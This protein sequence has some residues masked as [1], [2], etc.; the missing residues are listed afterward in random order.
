MNQEEVK[1]DPPPKRKSD[2]TSLVQAELNNRILDLLE[3]T[4]KS[5]YALSEKIESL[6]DIYAESTKST[7]EDLRTMTASLTNLGIEIRVSGDALERL[8]KLQ[9]EIEKKRAEETEKKHKL[10]ANVTTGFWQL[11]NKPINIILVAAA[12]YIAYTLFGIS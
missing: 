7:R 2:V 4:W 10:L 9:I 11:V 3:S 6:G 5:N 8:Y 12:A 1:I